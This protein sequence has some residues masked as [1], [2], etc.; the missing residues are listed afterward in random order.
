MRVD[1]RSTLTAVAILTFSSVAAPAKAQLPPRPDSNPAAL[2]GVLPTIVTTPSETHSSSTEPRLNPQPLAPEYSYPKP[3][4]SP[5]PAMSI[6]TPMPYVTP[7]VSGK[8]VHNKC[9]VD[10]SYVAISFDDGPHPTLTPKLLDLLKDRNVKATFYVIGKNVVQYPEIV[11]RM[12]DEGHEVGNHTWNHP[13]LTKLSSVAVADEI[14][15]TTKAIIDACGTAPT[16]MRPPYGATNAALNKRMSQEFGLPVILW[17]VDPQDWKI[18]RASHVSN[19]LIQNTS[20]GD[21]LLAHD[22][23]ASTVDAMPATLDALL[24]KGYKFATVTELIGMERAPKDTGIA[25]EASN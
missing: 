7:A 9:L 25:A 18:R 23:H 24:A 10:D 22:I 4:P 1:L 14:Q 3:T 19:H 17:S 11:Q 8:F 16:T 12:I 2:Q 15:K 5:D 13:A 21:I 6:L 20:V